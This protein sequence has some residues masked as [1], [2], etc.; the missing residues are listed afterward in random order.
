[1]QSRGSHSTT[2]SSVAYSLTS[3]FPTLATEPA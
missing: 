2:T 3:G 1:M